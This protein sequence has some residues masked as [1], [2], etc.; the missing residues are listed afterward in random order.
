MPGAT[1]N[2]ET[3]DQKGRVMIE[4]VISFSL[5]RHE[6]IR[7]VGRQMEVGSFSR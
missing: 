3:G 5:G 7:K 2:P 6:N 1:V 4:R